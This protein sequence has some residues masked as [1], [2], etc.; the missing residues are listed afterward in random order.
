[1][2]N[3]IGF[4]RLSRKASHR[5]ALHK[6]MAMSLF[7]H[8]RI[9]TTKAKAYEVRRTVEKLITRARVDS[10][11]NRRIVAK[12]V[13]DRDI[14]RKL[15]DDI[16]P[17]YMNR[18]GGY[19][20]VLKI[21]QR[22]N[23]AAEMVLFELVQGEEVSDKNKEEAKSSKG[24]TKSSD[25]FDKGSQEKKSAKGETSESSAQEEVSEAN[26]DAVDSVSDDGQKNDDQDAQPEEEKQAD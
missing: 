8:E 26:A 15:F 13:T 4:N 24:E 1:M 6:N 16:A 9:R 17:R 7:K 5:K 11:H 2:H 22:Q 3:R 23:D 12:K 10:V 21:G 25:V 19:T 14:L 20:R 18:N